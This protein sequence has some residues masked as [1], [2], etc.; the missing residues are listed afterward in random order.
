MRKGIRSRQE[1]NMSKVS[2]YGFLL[3]VAG[4]LLLAQPL[5]A[6]EGIKGNLVDVQWL[7]KNLKNADVLILDASPAKNYT[8]QHIPGAVSVDI[9]AYGLP[10]TPAAEME[11]RY[12]SWGI[13]SGKKIVIYDQGGTM[14][15]T[16]LFFSF[17]YYGFPRSLL[18]AGPA[19]SLMASCC[20][21]P[22]FTI[23]ASWLKFWVRPA[24]MR[25]THFRQFQQLFINPLSHNK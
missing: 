5:M 3:A 16:R 18:L 8:A 17:C 10:E 9:M 20:P 11:K 1:D 6:A 7:E 22:T 23:P 4:C 12:Q 21:V 15:A 24:S 2:K 14:Q 13:S 19:I 25:L